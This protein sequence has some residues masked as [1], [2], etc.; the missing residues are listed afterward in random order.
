MTLTIDLYA[1]KK[2]DKASRV[3]NVSLNVVDDNG[4]PVPKANIVIGEG[5]IHAVTD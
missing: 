4:S 5:L 1:Q 2:T 3:I